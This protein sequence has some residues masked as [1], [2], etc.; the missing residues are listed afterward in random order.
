[1]IKN[2]FILVILFSF[3]SNAAP[4][5][6][7]EAPPFTHRLECEF[8]YENVQMMTVQTNAMEV[9]M[10]A[11]ISEVTFQMAPSVIP[12]IQEPIG[13]NELFHFTLDENQE[14]NIYVQVYDQLYK[15][16]TP[17]VFF[18]KVTNPGIPFL[19]VF[20]G[21]CNRKEREVDAESKLQ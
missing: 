9:E 21:F 15:S 8:Y 2:S 7:D 4:V 19:N 18:S 6:A 14:K 3:F 16:D 17:N 11:G 13:D 20:D 5:N 12:N 1:M 10:V